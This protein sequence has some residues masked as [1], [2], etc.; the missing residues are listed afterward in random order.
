MRRSLETVSM[1]DEMKFAH[2]D[3]RGKDKSK[4]EAGEK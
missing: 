1:E 4:R 3:G 2:R